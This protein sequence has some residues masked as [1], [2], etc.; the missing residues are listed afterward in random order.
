MLNTVIPIFSS[1]GAGAAGTAYE[2]IATVTVGSGGASEINFSS[3]GTS[4]S[5]LQLRILARTDRGAEQDS[6]KI[7]F[8]ND[9]TSGN[10]YQSHYVS[11]NGATVSVDAQGTSTYIWIPR[12]AASTATASNFGVAVVDVLDYKSTNKHKT[13]RTLGGYD[14]NGSGQ[15]WFSSGLWFPSTISAISS[16]KLTPVSGSNFTQYSHFALY[17]IKSA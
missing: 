14:N 15:I 10:Y 17:G 13:T 3:I 1:A 11:G 6:A 9:T 4:W 12:F 5:H 16:I 8:N 2:S 7:Q